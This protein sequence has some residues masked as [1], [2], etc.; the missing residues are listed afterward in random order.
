[1]IRTL[2][3][4]PFKSGSMQLLLWAGIYFLINALSQGAV[5][6]SADLDQAQQLYLSQT[7]TWGYGSQPPLYSWISYLLFLVTGPS[8]WILL[9]V[10]AFLLTGIIAGAL[11]IG[12]LLQFSDEDKGLLVLGFV[13]IPQFIWESQR[14]LTHSVM[15]TL[16]AIWTLWAVLRLTDRSGWKDYALLGLLAGFGALSKYNYLFFAS[17]LFIAA[18]LDP[19]IRSRV[20]NW[21]LAAS[22]LVFAVIVSPHFL[23]V[24][25]NYLSATSNMGKLKISGDTDLLSGM[26]SLFIAMLSY[27]GL[28]LIVVFLA[29]PSFNNPCQLHY[30]QFFYRLL[31]AV[32]LFMVVFVI[33][34]GAT[35]VKD[36]WFQPMLFFLPFLAIFAGVVRKRLYQRV[37]LGMLLL[38]ILLLPGRTLLAEFTNKVS[39]PNLPYPELTQLLKEIAG[40][41]E[42]I[43]TDQELLAGNLR[44]AFD[45]VPIQVVDLSQGVPVALDPFAGKK[46][47]FVTDEIRRPERV[48]PRL[49]SLE[50]YRGV[51]LQALSLPMHYA[52]SQMHN[53]YWTF[54]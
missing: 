9:I 28:L 17:A 29:K 50:R 26:G 16:F 24:V 40:T 48:L 4:E 46:V 51:T 21:K 12:R 8:L 47:L 11:Q 36:R 15:A 10:K 14:D 3:D 44:L 31:L 18:V 49:R 52:P 6:Q 25:D 2:T 13:F 19:Y 33:L 23:W 54:L 41:P 43:V 42:Q 39:R 37:A 45:G 5:S 1:M 30:R 22:L 32:V 35:K 53:I 7:L 38:S 27:S 34:T 20:L